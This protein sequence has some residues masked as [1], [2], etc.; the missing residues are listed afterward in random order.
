MKPFTV[1]EM[2]FKD[3]SRSSE[4]CCSHLHSHSLH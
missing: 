1:P 3:H 4:M 2:T